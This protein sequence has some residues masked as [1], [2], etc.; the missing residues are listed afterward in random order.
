MLDVCILRFQKYFTN[1]ICRNR[2]NVRERERERERDFQLYIHKYQ[3][4]RGQMK[5][6]SPSHSICI[7]GERERERE[8]DFK[9]YIHKYQVL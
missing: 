3:G 1:Y 6:R 9:L 7:W 5:I 8:R 2:E 4:E